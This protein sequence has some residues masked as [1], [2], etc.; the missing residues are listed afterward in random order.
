MNLPDGHRDF[1]TV[2]QIDD[3]IVLVGEKHDSHDSAELAERVLEAV[4]AAAEVPLQICVELPPG[5][6]AGGSGM[7]SAITY[8]RENS[9]PR[10]NI[11]KPRT[12]GLQQF[13]TYPYPMLN[14]ANHFEHPVQENG[15]V[16]SRAISYARDLIA[17]KYGDDVYDEMYTK[18]EVAMAGRLRELAS[19]GAPVLAFVGA[20]HVP[21]IKQEYES[22]DNRLA[23]VYD[24]ER[25][26]RNRENS[27]AAEAPA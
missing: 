1:T 5:R 7:G 13:D 2:E 22:R 27:A 20:F 11:D 17:D 6:S 8:A 3:N 21:A 4:D 15:D 26:W 23:D 19:D 18:R 16:D 9:Y 10:Y 24:D 25:S 12:G 14:D